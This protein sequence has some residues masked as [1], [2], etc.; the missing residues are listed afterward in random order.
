M[1]DTAKDNNGKM[2]FFSGLPMMKLAAFL[3][4]LFLSTASGQPSAPPTKGNTM[5]CWVGGL[6][7]AGKGE[8][9]V[10]TSAFGMQGEIVSGFGLILTVEHAGQL[11]EVSSSLMSL[12]AKAGTYS[13]QTLPFYNIRTTLRDLI[14]GYNAGTYSQQFSP[15]EDDPDAKLQMQIDKVTITRTSQPRFSRLH[16]M[17]SFEFNAAA[18]PS[19]SPSD[20]C[21]SD[22]VAR[23]LA[24]VKAGKRLLPLYDAK[25]CGA[26]KKH[27]RCDFDVSAELVSLP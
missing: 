1:H 19:S 14:K 23:S 6:K 16:A 27:V 5:N 22:G 4:V 15:I 12:P 8:P 18:L 3:P 26:E 10:V 17:G 25:V 24:S 2:A 20:A 9:E 13:F 7:L 11:H 21:V